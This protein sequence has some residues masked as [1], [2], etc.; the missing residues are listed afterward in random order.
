MAHKS[1]PHTRYRHTRTRLADLEALRTALERKRPR[2]RGKKA[3][4]TR[5]LNK[6]ARQI[7]AAKGVLTKARNAIARN[8]AQRKAA[9]A[10]DKQKRG[11]AAKN[12]WA[13]RR[14]T[15]PATSAHVAPPS[16]AIRRMRFLEEHDGVA[17]GIEVAPPDRADRSA[18]GSYWY[19]VGVL[20][21]NGS[22]ALLRRFDDRSIYDSLRHKRLPFVTDPDLLLEAVAADLT[23]FDDLYIESSWT[24]AA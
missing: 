16:Q 18:I 14:G 12:G 3:A 1:S 20:R 7:P 10:A 2:T 23:D 11:A 9:K 21:D 8:A 5:S 6:L 17:V 22:T 19:A 15:R 24:S 4:K 13:K